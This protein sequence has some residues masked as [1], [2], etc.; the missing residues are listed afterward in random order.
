LPGALS[1]QQQRILFTKVRERDHHRYVLCWAKTDLCVHHF[2]DSLD[3]PVTPQS[4]ENRSPYINTKM[5]DLIT[6]CSAC[7]GKVHSSDWSSPLTG[8][9]RSIIK[10]IYSANPLEA[11][12]VKMA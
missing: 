9:L 1:P 11:K 10:E 8:L 2:W 6:L 5:Y 4:E 12:E 3:K 7:H